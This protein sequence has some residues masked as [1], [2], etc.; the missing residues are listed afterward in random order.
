MK[1]ILF[2]FVLGMFS[3]LVSA[4][5]KREV[6]GVQIGSSLEQ[7]IAT[8]KGKGL[9]LHT[10]STEYGTMYILDGNVFF[11]GVSWE[12]ITILEHNGQVSTILF[13]YSNS[14]GDVAS[15]VAIKLLK[16]LEEK[17]ADYA[18]KPKVEE[19]NSGMEFSATLSD[20]ITAINISGTIKKYGES[21]VSLIYSDIAAIKDIQNSEIDDL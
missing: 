21:S 11:A 7:T 6:Y 18:Q 2:L 19:K 5:I 13:S 3:C 4:Q 17:Y 10:Q 9:S 16:N 12:S 20:E 14:D 1:K 8:L 15:N